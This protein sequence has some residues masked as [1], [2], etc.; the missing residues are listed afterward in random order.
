MLTLMS[1]AALV[2][3]SEGENSPN[4]HQ[5]MNGHTKCSLSVQ[6]EL[7][8]CQ[9]RKYLIGGVAGWLQHLSVIQNALNLPPT[10]TPRHT[11]T[12]LKQ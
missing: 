7:F 3:E 6:W 5:L 4:V 11:L 2:T 8:G 9:K 10:H 1:R 12:R